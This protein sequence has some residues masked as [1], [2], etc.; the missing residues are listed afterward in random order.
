[1]QIASRR[2][3]T[4][5]KSARRLTQ[6]PVGSQTHRSSLRSDRL[7]RGSGISNPRSDTGIGPQ[8]PYR[9]SV[10]GQKKGIPKPPRVSA[11]S[12]PWEARARK[13]T[14]LSAQ[15][16]PLKGRYVKLAANKLSHREN[17][18]ECVHPRWPRMAP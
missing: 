13:N 10:K 16:L 18:S 15:K 5:R 14:P 9:C 6:I 11:S 4:T 17:T 12:K 1:A 3:L 2:R 8:L 7:R